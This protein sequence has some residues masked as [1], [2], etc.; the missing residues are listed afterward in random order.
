MS[1]LQNAFGWFW[2]LSVIEISYSITGILSNYEVTFFLLENIA[3]V[4]IFPILILLYQ[5]NF[6]TNDNY[7]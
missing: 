6:L 3:Q 2:Q 1:L 4:D 7:F 5:S